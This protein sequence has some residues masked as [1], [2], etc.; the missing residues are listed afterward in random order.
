LAA[1]AF[2]LG[3]ILCGILCGFLS[4]FPSVSSRVLAPCF[5]LAYLFGIV[6]VLAYTCSAWYPS[7]FITE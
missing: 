1:A 3:G 4:A 2:V 6:L 7:W 5:V